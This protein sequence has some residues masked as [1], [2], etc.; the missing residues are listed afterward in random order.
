MPHR[1]DAPEPDEAGMV[2]TAAP[3]TFMLDEAQIDLGLLVQEFNGVFKETVEHDE[4][5][6]LD[7]WTITEGACAFGGYYR[8][9]RLLV[10]DRLNVEHYSSERSCLALSGSTPL[11]R[12]LI[13]T[14]P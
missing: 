9:K 6:S 3:W 1:D 4:H 13:K 10:C 11:C 2:K 8:R 5:G 12:S 14:L 7:V